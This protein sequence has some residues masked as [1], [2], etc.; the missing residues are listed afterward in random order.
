VKPAGTVDLSVIMPYCNEFPQV[1][2]TI[3]GLAE[4][5]RGRVNFEILPVNNFHRLCR[6]DGF[7]VSDPAPDFLEQASAGNSW[8]RPLAYDK[9]LSHWQAKNFA[10]TQTKGEFLLFVDA[11][12]L[13]GRSGLSSMFDYYQKRYRALNGSIHPP[14]TY[15]ILEW[16][17]LIYRHVVDL[18]KGQLSYTFADFRPA[19]SPYLVPCMSSCGML[20]HREIYDALGG[21]PQALGSYSGGEQF[22]NYAMAVL[23]KNV[24]I[25]PGEPLYHHGD[26]RG[27]TMDGLDI[28][29]NQCIATYVVAGEEMARRFL[30]NVRKPVW[31]GKVRADLMDKGNLMQDVIQKCS[32]HREL[33]V[34]RQVISLENWLKQ[35]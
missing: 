33:I 20:V 3:R 13:P 1:L 11:H 27:Y 19:F 17:R 15:Q 28:V 32:Q 4:E 16:R 31:Q 22:W 8:L 24:W 29:R 25:W 9:G 6:Y 30:Q 21:W 35:W 14:L 2:F 23:G 26:R 7:P 5:F 12:T 10:V 34:Q 18:E